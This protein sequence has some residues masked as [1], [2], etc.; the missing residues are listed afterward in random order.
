MHTVSGFGLRFCISN[1]LQGDR[2][3]DSQDDMS[4]YKIPQLCFPNWP[5]DNSHLEQLL[6]YLI[7][8][9]GQKS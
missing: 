8:S 1:N 3:T 5:F 9:S 6:N 7:P 4:S 2:V